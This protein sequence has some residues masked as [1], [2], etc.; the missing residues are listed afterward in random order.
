LAAAERRRDVE[1]LDD[2]LQAK[3]AVLP[4]VVLTEL[5]SDPSLSN[6][7]AELFKT[8]P[9]LELLE[10]YWER[11]GCQRARVL[12]RGFKARIADALIAQSCL[13]HKL[14]LLTRDVDLKAFSDTCGLVLAR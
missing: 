3:Q 8:I 1:L 10:G 2:A 6:E 11:A 14:A 9:V 4:P 12:A 7:L 13:D 5:L